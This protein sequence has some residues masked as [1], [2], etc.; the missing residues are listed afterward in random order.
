MEPVLE[1]ITRDTLIRMLRYALRSGA[2]RVEF[3][4]GR[5]PLVDGMGGAREL[6][7]RQLTG[8][9]TGIVAD[10][11]LGRGIVSER[12]S[13]STTDGASVLPLLVEWKQQALFDARLTSVP[14]GLRICVDVIR[15]LPEAARRAIEQEL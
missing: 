8:E 5:R 4:P 1:P 2:D 6:R 3:Q 13:G 11:F 7:H 12:L 9:D 10:Y 14:G 15:P